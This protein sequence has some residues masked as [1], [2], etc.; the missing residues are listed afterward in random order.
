[1]DSSIV[2]FFHISIQITQRLHALGR[3]NEVMITGGEAVYEI[4]MSSFSTNSARS[5]HANSSATGP[6]QIAQG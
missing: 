2:F 3:D 6:T 1:M 4:K 5:S